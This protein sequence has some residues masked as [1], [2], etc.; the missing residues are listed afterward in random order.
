MN[1]DAA[2]V[3]RGEFEERVALAADGHDG[4]FPLQLLHGALDFL[5]RDFVLEVLPDFGDAQQ[6]GTAL[7]QKGLDRLVELV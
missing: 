2:G 1:P 5:A 3:V 7:A 6:A 4:A